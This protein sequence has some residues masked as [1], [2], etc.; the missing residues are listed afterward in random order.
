VT[1][2][3]RRWPGWVYDE[4]EEP[5]YRFTFANE[6]TFLAWIRTSLALLAGGVAV[7][8]FDLSMPATL[9]RVLAALL[10][11]LALVCAVASFLRWARAERAMRH[12]APIGGPS[13]SV[14]VA[15]GLALVALAVVVAEL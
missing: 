5:D 2:V 8:A 12:G 15:V 9:Q 4:G 1:G 10:S 13:L 14:I 6:R 3:G 11:L 7:D